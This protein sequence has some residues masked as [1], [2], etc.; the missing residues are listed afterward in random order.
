MDIIKDMNTTSSQFKQG[1]ITGFG[2]FTALGIPIGT[3][4]LVGLVRDYM[5]DVKELKQRI[6]GLMKRDEYLE[7]E[8]L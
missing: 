4:A 1:L 5:G 2:H 3:I 6:R 7:K 8:E